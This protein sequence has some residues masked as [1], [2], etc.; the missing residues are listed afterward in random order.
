[1]I[2]PLY[3]HIFKIS[4]HFPLACLTAKGGMVLTEV[5]GGGSKIGVIIQQQP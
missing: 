3:H 4:D 1:M 2:Q 5:G